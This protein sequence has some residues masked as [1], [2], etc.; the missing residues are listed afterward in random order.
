MKDEEPGM[1]PIVLIGMRC[2]SICVDVPGVCGV[3]VRARA[4]GRYAVVASGSTLKLWY[5]V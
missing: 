3:P 5:D 4:C 1:V 2:H